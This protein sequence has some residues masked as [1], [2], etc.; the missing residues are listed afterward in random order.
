MI[1]PRHAIGLAMSILLCFGAAWVGSRLTAPS[2]SGWYTS[3]RKPAW[4]PPNWVFGPVW[5]A[6]YLCMAIAAWL[7]W[8]KLELPGAKLALFLFAFQLVLNVCWSG[9]FFTLHNPG[10]AFV[11]I[12]VLWL[13]I[14]AT[15]LAFWPLS[16]A[17]SWLMAPYLLWVAFAAM[18]NYAIWRLNAF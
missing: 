1:S 15:A 12:V 11:E 6:L 8:R 4:T 14:L 13:S 2:L 18:L 10:A 5:S 17:A 16:Q 3:L 7:V 9:I